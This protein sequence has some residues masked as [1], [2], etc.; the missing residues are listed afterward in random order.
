MIRPLFLP[1]T[2]FSRA[3]LVQFITVPL[4]HS[5]NFFNTSTLSH[6]AFSSVGE[7]LRSLG[8]TFST[9]ARLE[10][11]P[12][13]RTVIVS[14]YLY[15]DSMWSLHSLCICNLTCFFCTSVA[16]VLNQAVSSMIQWR[17]DQTFL[18]KLAGIVL[19]AVLYSVSHSKHL[20]SYL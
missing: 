15:C 12:S 19:V 10:E 5:F 18:D 14:F 13:A 3:S 17:S 7:C 16:V 6:V 1:W 2:L 9:R 11:I 8:G 4:G 20:K